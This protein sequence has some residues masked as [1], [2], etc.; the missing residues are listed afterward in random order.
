MIY[1][2]I[3]AVFNS[4]DDCKTVKQHWSYT[5]V[6]A[7]LMNILKAATNFGSIKSL[8]ITSIQHSLQRNSS[9]SA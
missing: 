1:N 8:Q 9:L 2:I 7:C 3:I 6:Y 4:I 5:H